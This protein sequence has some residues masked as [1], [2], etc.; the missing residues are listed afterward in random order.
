MGV[1][2]VFSLLAF[3]ESGL[4]VVD[5]FRQSFLLLSVIYVAPRYSTY[6]AYSSKGTPNLF[7]IA[8]CE[9]VSLTDLRPLLALRL[10]GATA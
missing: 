5:D 7:A 6:F 2:M 4:R 3:R 9:G 8:T 1:P 10:A